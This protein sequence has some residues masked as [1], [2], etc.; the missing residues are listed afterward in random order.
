MPV[1][2]NRRHEKFAVALVCGLSPTQAY[3]A[4]RY[5]ESPWSRRPKE[6]RE[7]RAKLIAA[8]NQHAQ[9]SGPVVEVR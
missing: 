9:I 6:L 7:L 2:T 8:L 5:S 3:V 1:L 4:A